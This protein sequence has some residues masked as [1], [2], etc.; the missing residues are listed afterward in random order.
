LL[1]IAGIVAAIATLCL[2]LLAARPD[3]SSPPG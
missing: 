2:L 1:F 3:S